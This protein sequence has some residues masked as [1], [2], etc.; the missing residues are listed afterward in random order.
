MNNLLK[1]PI[2]AL[3]LASVACAARIGSKGESANS[4]SIGGEYILE[5]EAPWLSPIYDQNEYLCGSSLVSSQFVLTGNFDKIFKFLHKIAQF[6]DKKMLILKIKCNSI[7][8]A[9]CIHFKDRDPIPAS[10]LVIYVGAYN[11]DYKNNQTVQKFSAMFHKIHPN[12]DADSEPYDADIALIKLCGTVLF[13][14]HVQKISLPTDSF[15]KRGINGFVVGYGISENRTD[16][17]IMPRRVKIPIV[18]SNECLNNHP[19]FQKTL[20]RDT[21]CAGRKGV[22]ACK[23]WNDF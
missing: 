2:L 11:L 10:N 14:D 19:I 5:G 9:H 3:I 22:V 23:F 21:F 4:L 12:W 7:P 18:E 13:S 6:I 15:A 1:I 17:E 16:H 20:S 8:A